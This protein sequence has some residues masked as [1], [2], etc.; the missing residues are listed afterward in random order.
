VQPR[1]RRT[2]SSGAEILSGV[3]DA[4]RPQGKIG[5]GWGRSGADEKNELVDRRHERDILRCSG[6]AE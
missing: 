2:C 5:K 1:G 4:S 6:Q 3:M